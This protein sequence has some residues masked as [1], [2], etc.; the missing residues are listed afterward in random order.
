MQRIFIKKYFLFM[1]GSV[2]RVQWFHLDGKCFSD[3]EELDTEMQK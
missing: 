2:C 3:D 1:F